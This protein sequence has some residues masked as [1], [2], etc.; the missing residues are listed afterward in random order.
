[1]GAAVYRCS[2][3]FQPVASRRRRRKTRRPR[4]A[5][6]AA[7]AATARSPAGGP[8]VPARLGALA[9]PGG[10]GFLGGG[11]GAGPGGSHAGGPPFRSCLAALAGRVVRVSLDDGSER[12]R[13]SAVTAACATGRFVR[14]WCPDVA[15]AVAAALLL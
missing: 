15:A 11:P 12:L 5:A 10:G 7:G 4:I 13:G 3:Q 6:S 1:M 9:G 14:L 2:E 8:P